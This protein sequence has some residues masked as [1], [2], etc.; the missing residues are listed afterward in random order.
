M[1]G[2]VCRD[3][4]QGAVKVMRQIVVLINTRVRRSAGY[5][6]AWRFPF[7][8]LPYRSLENWRTFLAYYY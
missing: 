1:G 7:F 8:T 6:D 2:R 4:A 5:G 3:G